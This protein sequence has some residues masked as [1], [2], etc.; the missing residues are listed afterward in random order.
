VKIV[1]RDQLKAFV[2]QEGE[3]CLQCNYV[4]AKCVDVCPNRANISIAV[5]GF[6]DRF[7][8]LHVDAFCNECGNC[9][10]FC[11]WQGRPYKD[12]VTI[13]SLRQD[14]DGSTNA[15]FL[16]EG[17]TVHVRHNGNVHVLSIDG[18]GRI[19]DAPP[20][21]AELC[22]IIAEVRARHDYLLGPVEE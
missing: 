3:R 12:K 21:L 5:P 7:Q 8:T 10:S 20:E 4:C 18:A 14:F 9:A 1:E 16:M 17:S 11:P 19:T 15:G 13:F 2:T 6:N 22:R